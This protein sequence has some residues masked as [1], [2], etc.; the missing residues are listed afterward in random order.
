[1]KSVLNTRLFANSEGSAETPEL[2]GPARTF[3]VRTLQGT[4]WEKKTQ[5][6]SLGPVTGWVCGQTDIYDEAYILHY[7]AELN[8][9][10]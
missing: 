2:R 1:M 10:W 4:G 8:K 9:G 3:A 7:A 5:T 6:G